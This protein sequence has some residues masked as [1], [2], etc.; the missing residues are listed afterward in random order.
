MSNAIST[1]GVRAIEMLG[2]GLAAEQVA[3]TLG[4]SPSAI[5]QLLAKEEISSQAP[6]L[7]YEALSKHN[8]RDNK[9]DS[10]EDRLLTKYESLMPLMMRP[11]EAI[12]AYQ[13]INGASAVEVL[14]HK[15]LLTNRL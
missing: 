11:M 4:V 7:R 14:P 2:S 12:K 15:S 9:A 10:I 5:S 8:A 6:Q 1:I 13:I 3:G